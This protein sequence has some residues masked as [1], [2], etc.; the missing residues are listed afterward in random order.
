M[1]DI[2]GRLAAVIASGGFAVTGEVVPPRAAAGSVVSEHARALVGYV[3]AVNVTDNPVASAHMSPLAGARFVAE[4]GIEPTLQI[5]ARDRNRLA[6]TADLLGGWALGARNLLCL[7]GDPV[8]IGDHAGAKVV[9]DLS[10]N[11]LV[12]L[13]RRLRDEGTTLGVKEVADPPGYLIGV[14]DV[15]LADPYDPARLESKIEAGADVIWTQITYDVEALAAWASSLWDRGVFE[16]AKALIGLVPLRSAAQ[17]RAMQEKLP[18]VSVPEA[19]IRR[20]EEAGDAA[21]REGI[22]ITVEVV[23]A[24][25]GL[26]GVAGVHLMG[27]GRDDLVREVVE[28][29]GLFPRPVVAG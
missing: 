5:T 9:A 18:G 2:G 10:V 26:G 20:L 15:P 27:M 14:A 16:R 23:Q 11:E 25:R 21:E 13:A 19:F 17:A 7:T 29:A 1:T 8:H 28:A 3:D 6:L 4:A 24:L 12:A 22:V